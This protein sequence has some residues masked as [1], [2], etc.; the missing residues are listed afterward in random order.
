MGLFARRCYACNSAGSGVVTDACLRWSP[1]RWNGPQT[2]RLSF[3]NL[4][5]KPRLHPHIP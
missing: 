3:L 5:V 2:T 4:A 1:Q